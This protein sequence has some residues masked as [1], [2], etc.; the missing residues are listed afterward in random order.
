LDLLEG[1]RGLV[2]HEGMWVAA[3]PALVKEV[4]T[5]PAC[6]VRPVAEPVPAA[7]AG[8]GAGEA[9]GSLARMND[10]QARHAV[11]KMALQRALASV[12]LDVVAVTA[13]RMAREVA[14]AEGVGGMGALAVTRW[15]EQV[16]VRT[17]A[18]LLGFV[19]A[20]LPALA[21]LVGGF[22]A[23]LSPLSSTGQIVAAHAASA[24]L[25]AAVRDMVRIQAGAGA[26][27]GAL[28][29][30][31]LCEA[32]CVGWRD[33][34]AI[35]ANLVGLLSQTYEATAGLIGNTLVALQEGARWPGGLE[36]ALALVREVAWR[37]PSVRNTRRFIAEDAHI[38]GVDVKTGQVILV[39]LAAASRAAEGEPSFGFGHG[40]HKCPGQQV[41][42]TIAAAA[43]ASLPGALPPMAWRY[44]ASHNARIPEFM[45]AE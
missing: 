23:C 28:A 8:G 19:D 25:L 24:E 32:E 33:E 44:R 40:A 9:F 29:A 42:E 45:E 38:G 10:G 22:V 27:R 5:H 7:I 20:Q 14:G 18:S 16:P 43:I 3:S 31:V 11:P 4:M 36:E 21:T 13:G 37:D 17:V 41:A 30:A 35:M 1:E 6:R 26:E 12:P 15:M 39:G 34:R 2:W